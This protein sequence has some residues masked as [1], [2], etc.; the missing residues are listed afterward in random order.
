MEKTVSLCQSRWSLQA[1]KAAAKHYDCTI[2]DLLT[3]V[4]AEVRD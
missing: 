1:T 2:N 4:I 3:T